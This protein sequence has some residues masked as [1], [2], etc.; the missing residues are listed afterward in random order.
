MIFSLAMAAVILIFHESLLKLLFG[1]V[2]NDVME[3]CVIYL[4]IT[5]Y[6][7]PALAIYNAGA[8]LYRSIGKTRTTMCLDWTVRGIVFWMRYKNGKW[9]QFRVI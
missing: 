8:A 4:R 7:Y 9:K 1:K 3:A 2:E 5:A 6:S